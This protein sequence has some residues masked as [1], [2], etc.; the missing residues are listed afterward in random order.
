LHSGNAPALC[1]LSL[2]KV[3]NQCIQIAAE[4]GQKRFA[5]SVD[6]FDN[7]VA[8]YLLGRQ[9]IPAADLLLAWEH[10]ARGQPQMEQARQTA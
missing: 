1:L 3:L 4:S 2:A 7:R 10:V 5:G 6:L 8:P 9:D